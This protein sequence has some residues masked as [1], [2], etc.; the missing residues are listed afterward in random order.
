M[1]QEFYISIETAGNDIIERYIDS[2]GVERQRRVEYS[3]TM[4]L[5]LN[6]V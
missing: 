1:A 6:K 2:N 5:M 4:F 3:P